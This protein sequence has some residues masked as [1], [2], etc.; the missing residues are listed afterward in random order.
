M[1]MAVYLV[2]AAATTATAAAA[3]AETMA[4]S[5]GGGATAALPHASAAGGGWKR[6]TATR[7]AAAERSF[8]FSKFLRLTTGTGVRRTAAVLASAAAAG[9]ARSA[10]TRRLILA[11]IINS[12]TDLLVGR[13]RPRLPGTPLPLREL[14][15]CGRSG[16]G[17]RLPRP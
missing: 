7:D 14:G 9:R 2:H 13:S 6:E 8:G 15:S 10:T 17:H 1:M 5:D 3:R 4:V 16:G 12:C 11:P